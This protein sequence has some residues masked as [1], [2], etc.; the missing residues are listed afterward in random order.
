MSTLAEQ[1][2]WTAAT[3]ESHSVGLRVAPAEPDSLHGGNQ[4]SV[5]GVDSSSQL[6]QS[7]RTGMDRNLSASGSLII[8]TYSAHP[9]ACTIQGGSCFRTIR[10]EGPHRR[11]A[12]V[13]RDFEREDL[14]E[15]NACGHCVGQRAEREGRLALRQAVCTKS[16]HRE[17]RSTRS[18][19]NLRSAL[20]PGWWRTRPDPI[21]A[22]TCIGANN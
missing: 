20:P 22:W 5:A 6:A 12:A 3:V 11:L 19:A 13:S 1:C 15:S 2:R 7:S 10:G 9:S 18:P 8:A 4:S 16:R 21:S 14:Q 17:T